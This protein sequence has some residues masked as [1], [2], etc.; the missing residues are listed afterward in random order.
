VCLFW[1]NKRSQ[2]SLKDQTN[3]LPY[4]DACDTSGTS[5]CSPF[6]CRLPLPAGGLID[7]PN[8]TGMKIEAGSLS[9]NVNRG[10]L[11]PKCVPNT[12][13]TTANVTDN[14]AAG[15]VEFSIL[16]T[17]GSVF[18]LSMVDGFFSPGEPGY[19]AFGAVWT[20][21]DSTSTFTLGPVFTLAD[22]SKPL[23]FPRTCADCIVNPIPDYS[24]CP[25]LNDPPGS[26][27]L[28]KWYKPEFCHPTR[29]CQTDA[30][31]GNGLFNI[32][33]YASIPL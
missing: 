31:F 5:G 26:T 13:Y 8:P 21:V 18:D 10:C 11:N 25:I 9:F 3:R 27:T 20:A 30:V 1:L 6:F 24:T 2:P 12:F 16:P 23:V 17:L 4:P 19:S 14:C 15:L 29:D 28:T 22:Q 33:L 32:T 7:I